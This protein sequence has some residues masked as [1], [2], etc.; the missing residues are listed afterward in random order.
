MKKVTINKS[1]RRLSGPFTELTVGQRVQWLLIQHKLTQTGAA[2]LIGISQSTIANIIGSQGRRPSSQTLM[3]MAR[4]L[5]CAPSFILDGT[6]SQLSYAMAN[7][8]RQAELLTMFKGLDQSHQEMV[9]IFTR[10]LYGKPPSSAQAG[11]VRKKDSK[12]AKL[13]APVDPK[14]EQAP[15]HT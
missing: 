12:A 8:D 10:A 2:K 13:L 4:A 15:D 11:L 5:N 3:K 9:L 7:D 1:Y 14:S 6:G